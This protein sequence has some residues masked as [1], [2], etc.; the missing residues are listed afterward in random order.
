M[1]STHRLRP[2][3]LHVTT[4]PPTTLKPLVLVK[5]GPTRLIMPTPQ[6]SSDVAEPGMFPVNHLNTDYRLDVKSPSVLCV[7]YNIVPASLT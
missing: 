6:P 2:V 1:P 3:R 5:T 7:M 4:A